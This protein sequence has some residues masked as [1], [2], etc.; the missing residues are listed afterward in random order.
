MPIWAIF[1]LQ[2][3][4]I[5]SMNK[6]HRHTDEERRVWQDPEKIL[7]DIGLKPGMT[8]ADIGCGRGFFAIPAARIVGE[9]G[10]VLASD[11]DGES[12][13]MLR[14]KAKKESLGNILTQAG[15]AEG[16]PI[17]N[18]CADVVFFGQCLHDFEDAK[19]ALVNARKAVKPGGL[20]AN[21]DWKKERM[22][23]GP[24]FDIRFSEEHASGLI[25]NAGFDVRSVVAAGPYHYLIVAA[26]ARK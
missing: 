10:K 23:M 14:E 12:V 17:C 6:F 25:R 26:P 11:V 7:A 24:P 13:E 16:Q 4:I 3:R 1:I 22:E 2:V 5:S 9:A 8:F 18:G 15:K 20:L 19:K 21:L